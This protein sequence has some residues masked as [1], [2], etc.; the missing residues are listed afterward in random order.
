MWSTLYNLEW[1][2]LTPGTAIGCISHAGDV[3]LI[4]VGV[5]H[6]PG[7]SAGTALDV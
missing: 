4:L 1:Q 7:Q 2:L 3:E 5:E 6:E